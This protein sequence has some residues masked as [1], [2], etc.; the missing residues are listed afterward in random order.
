[1]AIIV[2]TFYGLLLLVVGY[3]LGKYF[4]LIS[5][6]KKQNRFEK[7][8][9]KT[10]FL[11]QKTMSG[12]TYFLNM[13]FFNM[14]VFALAVFLIYINNYFIVPAEEMQIL[15]FPMI[16]HTAMSFITNT[17][18]IAFNPE[19]FMTNFLATFILGT[20]MFVAPISAFTTCYAFIRG[21]T[22]RTIDGKLGNFYVDF[23]RLLFYYFLP[24]AILFSLI[25]I[26]QGV[27]QN[28]NNDLVISTIEGGKQVIQQG[29]VASF[30]SIKLIGT[31]GG[32]FF[33]AN[34][35]HP[36]EN[37][38]LL[39]NFL[40]VFFMSITSVGIVFYFGF[41]LKNKKQSFAI[42]FTLLLLFAIGYFLYLYSLNSLANSLGQEIRFSPIFTAL[43]MNGTTA[44]SVGATNSIID[45]AGPI[46]IFV[47]LFNMLTSIVFGGVGAGFINIMMYV[48][49]TIYLV[50]LL[51][52]HSPEFHKKKIELYEV[53]RLSIALFMQP[54]IIL[55]VLA[56]SAAW[57]GNFDNQT[58]TNYMYTITTAI[59]N[60]GSVP[61]N[62][63]ISTNIWLITT[64][65]LMFIGRYLPIYLMLTVSYSLNKKH[66]TEEGKNSFKTDTFVFSILLLIIIVV[67][68]LLTFI[69]LLILGPLAPLFA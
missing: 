49:L 8:I 35:A 60:N 55:L 28:F 57:V 23:I 10:L 9:F 6:I 7:I 38:T 31:N 29:P 36:F 1:M 15:S 52:G 13:L 65:L 12:T 11:N 27:I 16:L 4:Y 34:S 17:N 32:S 51:V 66:S 26:T 50:G 62:L 18:L 63:D 53:V 30:E 25:L 44:F 68:S 40:Q 24:L 59:A 58:F 14:A 69:P 2:L 41:M 67:I 61:I 45:A 21:I 46:G 47:L 48:F 33:S 19:L 3:F 37:P 20:L 54:L 43:F 5:S 22:G 42:F 64:T 56:V 39:S